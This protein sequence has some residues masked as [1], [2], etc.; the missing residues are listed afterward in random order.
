MDGRIWSARWLAGGAV[1]VAVHLLF[2]VTVCYLYRFLEGSPPQTNGSDAATNVLLALQFSVIHSVLLLPNVRRWFQRAI[3]PAFYGLFFCTITCITLLLT[4]ACWQVSATCIWELDG[5]PG[6]VMSAAFIA[7][8]G[9]LLYSLYLSGLGYQTGF[10]PWWYWLRGARLPTRKFNP[11]GAYRFLR[12]PVYLSFMGL[13]WF[14]PHMTTD[15]LVLSLVWS[16]YIFVG[17][18]LKDARLLYF[19]GDQYREYQAR[20][21]GYPGMIVGP[22]AR[23]PW[24]RDPRNVLVP[25]PVAV[26]RNQSIDLNTARQSKSATLCGV[27]GK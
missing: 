2:A 21:P 1:G 3:A 23:R 11:R 18:W 4:F 6:R 27:S 25:A 8:W 10:T 17:S 13:L 26:A 20:V 7:T 24:V 12:H 9:A 16:A 22:L 19:L 5:V 14:T 15:R